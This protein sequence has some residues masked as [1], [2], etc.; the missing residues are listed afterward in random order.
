MQYSFYPVF[1]PLL[2]KVLPTKKQGSHGLTKWKFSDSTY[3]L[4]YLEEL[5]FSTGKLITQSMKLYSKVHL[6]QQ[7][8]STKLMLIRAPKDQGLCLEGIENITWQTLLGVFSSFL[9]YFTF[10]TPVLL[11]SF[12]KQYS[13]SSVTILHDYKIFMIVFRERK[14]LQTLDIVLYSQGT[15]A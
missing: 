5:W 4:T 15:L 7:L 11:A 6:L 2:L 9:T 13:A 12:M 14:I 10:N 1:L 3:P 8:T